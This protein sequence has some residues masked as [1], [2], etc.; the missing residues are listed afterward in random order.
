MRY[1]ASDILEKCEGI[2]ILQ[3]NIKELLKMIKEISQI[4]QLQG[5]K[6]DGIANHVK[7]TKDMVEKGNKNLGLAKEHH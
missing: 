7:Q 5:Q 1:K 6:L 2:K 4:V 3:K